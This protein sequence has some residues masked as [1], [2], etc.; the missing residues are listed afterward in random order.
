MRLCHLTL[1][2]FRNYEQAWVEF[3]PRMNNIYGP[4]ALGKTN[5]L[6][7][8]F[9]LII[10]RS[11]R[12]SS[13]QDLIQYGKA[14]FHLEAIFVKNDVEQ[15]LELWAN[16]KEKNI[17]YN[18]TRYASFS[19][20]LGLMQGVVL[21]PA[22]SLL[23]TAAP[24]LRRRYI[25]IQ[26]AQV[27]PLYVRH[28]SRYMRALKQRNRL[29]RQ[30]KREGIEVWEV[31]M[32][33][34]AAY[35]VKQRAL[36]IAFLSERAAEIQKILSKGKDL[37]ALSFKTSAPYQEGK[38]QLFD[39]YVRLYDKLR[40]K[41]LVLGYTLSGPHRDDMLIEIGGKEAR[42]CASEGQKNSCAVALRLAEWERLRDLSTERPLMA[43]DDM[44]SHLDKYRKQAISDYLS[45]LG[46]VFVTST[47]K[48]PLADAQYISPRIE[49]GALCEED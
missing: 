34:S 28:L 48:M 33:K 8:V 23:V 4:N 13:V 2:H 12:T 3:D 49:Q 5:L 20:L 32:A 7:A 15:K 26:I 38:E 14:S 22:D 16:G 35:V 21:A 40:V 42:L 19:D 46:Q 29:L 36:A 41:E 45:E 27:D 30:K 31:E 47:D 17:L 11:F 44:G 39:Y 37:L 43:I 6:E 9:F 10:G 25:D 24:I 18:S 1:R